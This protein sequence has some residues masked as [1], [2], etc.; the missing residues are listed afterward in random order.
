MPSM[1]KVL[2]YSVGGLFAL[3]LVGSIVD[4][5]EERAAESGTSSSAAAE[6]AVM[7]PPERPQLELTMPD[8][9]DVFRDQVTLTGRVRIDASLASGESGAAGLRGV[10]VTVD[11][12]T[13]PLRGDRWSKTI[14]VERG[15]NDV[16]VRAEADG[17]DTAEEIAT[18]TRKQSQAERAAAAAKR[19]AAAAAAKQRYLASAKLIPYNQL[20]KNA[21][22][23][24]GERV[25]FTGQIFQIQ[26]GYDS[27]VILL[28]VTDEGYGFWTDNIWVDYPG[29]IKGAEDDI[30]T[31][32]G[33]IEGSK[34]Y[35]TQIGGETYVPQM[36]AKYVEE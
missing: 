20:E 23:Y 26:E 10:R 1:K 7:P 14:T 13:A 19:A 31:V 21:D 9:R 24:S 22:R 11:G 12:K 18:L 16:Q 27:T 32:Y 3:G 15:T 17:M 2:G 36:T 8:D 28:S 4:P 25:K 29:T 33:T 35:E 30:I 34:S 6:P 5:P